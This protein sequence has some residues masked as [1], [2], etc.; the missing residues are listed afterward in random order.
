[1][2]RRSWLRVIALSVVVLSALTVLGYAFRPVADSSGSG[3]A[4][5]EPASGADDGVMAAVDRALGRQTDAAPGDAPNKLPPESAAPQSLPSRQE[6]DKSRAA[7]GSAVAPTAPGAPSAEPATTLEDRKIV[8]TATLRLQVKEVGPSF[9]EVGRIATGAGGFVAGSSFANQGEQQVASVSIRVP[10]V[11]YQEVL[12]QLRDLGAKV[13]SEASNASD[14]T[15]EYSDLSARQR[16]LEA[17]ESQLLQLLGRA[18]NVG[19]ILQVQDRLNSVR[20]EIERVKGRMSLLDKLSDMATINVQLRPVAGASNG[21]DGKVNLGEEI[22]EAW[23]ASLEFLASIAAG[24]LTVVVFAWWL[25]L[26]AV[27]VVLLGARWLR[28]RP[29][30]MAAVD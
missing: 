25:P 14:V 29:R 17:T 28:N 4:L 23:E 24:V 21:S 6:G 2:K 30:P 12:G 19:E 13:D 10:A 9:N 18:Q 8:Q 26:V 3:S 7:T 22:G 5:E 1:M 27:P 15:E 20:S 16:T 11:R